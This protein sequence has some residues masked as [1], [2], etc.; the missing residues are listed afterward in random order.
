MERMMMSLNLSL[1]NLM[2]SQRILGG[3]ERKKSLKLRSLV[4]G[5][6]EKVHGNPKKLISP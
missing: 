4:E 6:V 5:K 2:T 3:E 1:Q